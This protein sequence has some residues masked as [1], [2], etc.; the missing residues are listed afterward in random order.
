MAKVKNLFVEGK[1][2]KDLDE[3]L[4]P[5]GQY[6]DALNVRIGNS[7]GS[8]VGAIENSLSNSKLSDLDFGENPECIGACTNPADQMV[9]W[10]VVSD[11]GSYIAEYNDYNETSGII[12]SD[13]R[14]GTTNI[15]RFQKGNPIDCN[16]LV[17]DDNE[18][19]Y[20]YF[21][22]G[23]TPPKKIEIEHAKG[24]TNNEFTFDDVSVIVKPPIN[25]PKIEPRSTENDL[26]KK[27]NLKEKFVMFSY[28][29]KYRD[30]QYSAMSPFSSVAF[31]PDQYRF[32]FEDHVLECMV[33][34]YDNVD[35]KFNTGDVNVVEVDV[36]FKESGQNTIYL[37]KS[38][39]KADEGFND[40]E[41][42]VF[43][44]SNNQIYKVLPE[45]ELF[46][47]YDN[48]PLT[49]KTQE[50]I[51][52]RLVYG[53]YTE[54]YD[55]KNEAGDEVIPD[56]DLR[57]DQEVTE[58]NLPY[59]S[60]KSNRDYEVGIVYLDEHGRSTTVLS[61]GDS[62]VYVKPFA[63]V[64]KNSLT[65]V[66]KHK[67][68]KW[69]KYYRFFVK[70]TVTDY[71]NVCSSTFH[72]DDDE[73]DI[74]VKLGGDDVNKV[75]A[76]DFITMKRGT[77]G[78]LRVTEDLNI[79]EVEKK[80]R[81]FLDYDDSATD[82]EQEPGVYMAL[83]QRGS[84]LIQ[85]DSFTEYNYNEFITAR[86]ALS[87]QFAN[88]G[89]NL[90][91]GPFFYGDDEDT[92]DLTLVSTTYAP[93][94]DSSNHIRVEVEI[95]EKGVTADKYRV[96]Q[97]SRGVKGY[98]TEW[99]NWSD[100]QTCTTSD[101]DKNVWQDNS[102][103]GT[104]QKLT[105]RFGSANGHNV[106]DRWTFNYKPAGCWY[107]SRIYSGTNLKAGGSVNSADRSYVPI[108]F[109]AGDA[110]KIYAGSFATIDL[111][112]SEGAR[113]GF[114]VGTETI[115]ASR[116]YE[117]FEEFYY[118]E[119]VYQKIA[120][121]MS[122]T[123]NG[124]FTE[125][126]IS[127]RRGDQ[128]P[129]KPDHWK[130]FTGNTDD[131]LILV[132]ESNLYRNGDLHAKIKGR[133]SIELNVTEGENYT[134]LAE[135]KSDLKNTDVYYEI[136]KTYEVSNFGYHKGDVTVG[137]K[138]QNF[139]TNA[140]I[141]LDFF[142]C[143]GWAN[144]HESIRIKDSFFGT[145]YSFDTRP[146]TSIEKYQENER[147]AS[148]TYSNVYDQTTKYNGLNEFNLSTANYKDLDDADGDVQRVISRDTDLVV[149]QENKISKVLYN[150]NVLF[151]AGGDGSLAQTTEVLGQQI[152]Y[153]GEYGVTKSPQSIA[154]WG[155][156]IYLADPRRG[157][158]LRVSQ[159]GITEISQY[160]MRDWF[161]DNMKITQE[162][163]VLGGYDPENGQ[164]VLSIQ[165]PTIEWRE[166][167]V[168][169]ENYTWEIDET[170][171]LTED[172]TTTTTTTT[173]APTTTTTTTTTTEAPTT[174][175]TTST[176]TTST[177]TSTTTTS[178]TTTT[179]TTLAT[180]GCSD[181]A[182]S[183]SG[184]TT[185]EST[186]GQG[187]VSAGTI[188][189]ISPSTYVSGT[190]TYT[191]TITVP[192]GYANSGSSI[193]CTA[194]AIGT[195]TTTTTSTTTTSTT[196]TTTT[197]TTAAPVCYNYTLFSDGGETV[198]YTYQR[199]NTGATL[200]ATVPN[201]DSITVCARENSVTMSPDSGTIS[202]GDSCS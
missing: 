121:A 15:L 130:T 68:P 107:N 114:Q 45:K 104:Q 69:A 166:E 148:L 105:L 77:D 40:N 136:G 36:L 128:T 185:G 109:P 125:E 30:E 78:V 3:R 73:K 132:F 170:E 47:L 111:M 33:N 93:T 20:I 167:S 4:V 171:C 53:N 183:M 85:A 91:E 173:E 55:L 192:S 97:K 118:E 26:E 88:N 117:N 87:N 138:D 2:N 23:V 142:N 32:N 116:D 131:P 176:S 63:S 164:Y 108:Q 175:T 135:T 174:T 34:T 5:K 39:N 151:S 181:A 180:F 92:N 51:N 64:T 60:V 95:T 190:S 59:Q 139:E 196:T 11:D 160:G 152:P 13:N 99:T 197:T 201:G 110:G 67:A 17:D 147:R 202:Q 52:N 35:I 86:N 162:S 115:Y 134:F 65:A 25:P 76:G 124:K 28:R 163:K 12:L 106:G 195:D 169:C 41:E 50:I 178:T 96:R 57:Y 75:K 27:N 127:F 123:A 9:Y 102:G 143:F 58:V 168:E 72:I 156:R 154:T 74:Y 158:V 8:D 101:F 186:N 22:D 137:D 200:T 129:N 194:S 113:A 189:S 89:V 165:S 98:S 16:I 177:T 184:G 10:F 149:F 48:V 150:K 94:G 187:T 188:T 172:T 145:K 141:K 70:E 161:R 126:L 6:V 155:G 29:Y 7:S 38:F 18:K 119:K 80:E 83:K 79:R 100:Q 193:T 122:P 153:L 112:T 133:V 103:S 19:I 46:R 54:N 144:G 198:V 31:L 159:D 81:N 191:A 43:N 56:I 140:L 37:A 1:M 21:T 66:I 146:L 182:F 61:G 84:F 82:T 14:P 71:H 44:F 199:C 90:T 157:A 42:R 49:A 120:A 24:L 62:S 179:T